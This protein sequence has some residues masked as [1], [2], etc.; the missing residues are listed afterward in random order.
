MGS[1]TCSVLQY[2]VYYIR[3][4]MDD[5]YIDQLIQTDERLISLC[6]SIFPHIQLLSTVDVTST[7]LK[8]FFVISVSWG[9]RTHF[10]LTRLASVRKLCKRLFALPFLQASDISAEFEHLLAGS[11][12]RWKLL[13]TNNEPFPVCRGHL[14]G[15][16]CPLQ[17]WSVFQRPVRPN[18]D[19]EGWHYRLNA[20]AR[21]N[22]LPLYV[23]MELLY[24]EAV[25]VT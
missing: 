21:K 18:Y 2:R 13:S 6:Q 12:T 25:V 1:N 10:G 17:T 15:Q 19:L 3:A 16:S 22:S 5:K 8:P 4:I 20:K 11:L 14:D 7:G 23:L 9:C 24:R